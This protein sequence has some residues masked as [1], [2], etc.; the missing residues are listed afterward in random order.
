MYYSV[1]QS[2]DTQDY[3]LYQPE[4]VDLPY[5]IED[6]RSHNDSISVIALDD[7]SLSE[8]A[9]LDHLEPGDYAALEEPGH[10]QN[11][12]VAITSDE[13]FD[14]PLDY[15]PE[16]ERNNG[17]FYF[18]NGEEAEISEGRNSNVELKTRFP[19]ELRSY[20][21]TIHTHNV[22]EW[23]VCVGEFEMKLGNRNMPEK[24][25]QAFDQFADRNKQA[26][27]EDWFNSYEFENEVFR[28][29]PGV[30]HGIMNR[31]DDAY[32]TI[33]RGDPS[34]EEEWVGKWDLAGE[35]IYDHFEEEPN[36]SEIN[37]IEDLER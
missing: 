13:M 17:G 11:G 10:L 1:S 12:L 36:L 16:D 18:T 21:E 33:I 14:N 27:E 7:V 20:P 29:D 25:N 2:S 28:V 3:C 6:E 24:P 37:S 22:P 31:Q 9:H 8:E 35:Q 15:I 4:L 26:L 34:G 23:Y 30:Y 5:G 32:L 19:D